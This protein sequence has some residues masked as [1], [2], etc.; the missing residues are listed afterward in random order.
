M[1]KLLILF[2]FIIGFIINSQA[3]STSDSLNSSYN[4]LQFNDVQN[5]NLRLEKSH[6]QFQV[7]TI[8]QSL[9]IAT[10]IAGVLLMTQKEYDDPNK[11]QGIEEDKKIGRILAYTGAGLFT[12]GWVIH[13]D[14]HRLLVNKKP[15]K[16]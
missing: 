13:I 6:K 15:N 9:G 11:N 2:G 5:I 10:S 4:Q 3:Q 7:G 1:K 14:S 12:V 16:K 8:F